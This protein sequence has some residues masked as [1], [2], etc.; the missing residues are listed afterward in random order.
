M[1]ARLAVR[2]VRRSARDYTIYFV[3]LLLG[4]MVFYAFNSIADQRL[5]TD[6]NAGRS[7]MVATIDRVMAFF[8]VAVACV[9]GFLVAYSNR[10]ILRRRKHELGTYLLLGMK[11]R[12]V[13][14]IVLLETAL[15]GLFSLAAGLALGVVLSQLLCFASMSM[16]SLDLSSYRFV[17]SST[18]LGRTVLCFVVIFVVVG[19]LNVI[20]VSR[21]R[22]AT[23]LS[24]RSASERVGVRG[25]L[26]SA[27]CF[28]VSVA[29]LA[30]A[31]RL[32]ALNGLLDVGDA[33]FSAATALMLVGSLLFVSSVAGLVVGIVRRTRGL[34]LRELSPFTM[35]QLASR[36]NTAFVSLW[37]VCVLLFFGVTSFSVG[38]GVSSVLSSALEEGTQF[39][40]SIVASMFHFADLDQYSDKADKAQNTR[41]RLDASNWSAADY[42]ATRSATWRELVGQS[43]QVD[44][45]SDPDLTGGKLAQTVGYDVESSALYKDATLL[46]YGVSV[47]GVSQLNATRALSG[48]PPVTLPAGTYAV[49]NCLDLTKGLS[50]AVSSYGGTL[51]VGGV[52]L[53]SSRQLVRQVLRVTQLPDVQCVL[54]VPDDV[55]DA[56]RAIRGLPDMSMLNVRY[57]D[58]VDADQ[59][60]ALMEKAFAE[61]LPPSEEDLREGYDYGMGCWPLSFAVSANSTRTE[62]L[63]FKMLITFLALYLGFVLL[64]SA[65]SVLA[66]QQLSSTVDSVGRYRTLAQLGCTR[67]QVLGSVR[68]QTLLYFLVPLALALC[69]T[70]CVIWVMN[71]NLFSALGVSPL[72]PVSL[73]VGIV[74]VVYG[75]YLLV[76][77]LYCS[78]I[79]RGALGRRLL[80]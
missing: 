39:D 24:A 61:A 54:I 67:R 19:V 23:L 59:A 79:V 69:H 45:W 52:E 56:L 63:G 6:V 28:V 74:V 37:I 29:L 47:I 16:F 7:D 12:Q 18:A 26:P 25:V 34:Y 33:K 14:G 53:R 4:V 77:Y 11:A 72:V 38:M 36:I 27:L 15:V 9:L 68:T 76:T 50:E 44:I 22:L 41:E 60:E 75:G 70:A 8:S 71:R 55:I 78:A 40:H 62:A 30:Y 42:F 64:V 31:Y 1:L 46:R 21:C 35:R 5:M 49:D 65:G 10:F 51:R 43:A 66:V 80:A 20:E 58:G 17:L 32:L 57:A 3:T 13:A 73:A 2:N 48:H